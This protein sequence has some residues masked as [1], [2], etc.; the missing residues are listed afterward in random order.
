MKKTLTLALFLFWLAMPFLAAADTHPL[1]FDDFIKVKRLSD[2]QLSPR[3]DLL[4]FV[5]TEIDKTQNRSNSDIWVASV[6]GTG[7]RRLTSSPQA[8]FNP[9]WSPDG[10][11]I[12]FISTRGGSAQVWAIERRPATK[13]FT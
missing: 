4:A 7:L 10:K 13:W 5:V 12:A 1:S 9:R 3:G 11:T 8:D 2:V 6:D